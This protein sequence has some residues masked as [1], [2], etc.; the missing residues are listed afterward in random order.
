MKWSTGDLGRRKVGGGSVMEVSECDWVGS[1][2][3]SGR[4]ADDN[5]YQLNDLVQHC[6]KLGKFEQTE[7]VEKGLRVAK[8]FRNKERHGVTSTHA[9]DPTN[10]RDLEACLTEFYGVV[11]A[12]TIHHAICTIKYNTTIAATTQVNQCVRR[13]ASA[14]S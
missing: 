14:D 7:I 4:L 13:A 6:R 8:V 1:A 10:Y 3:K 2:G 12:E 9:F 5:A 11:F